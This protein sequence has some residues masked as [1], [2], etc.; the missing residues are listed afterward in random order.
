MDHTPAIAAFV[1][2]LRDSTVFGQVRITRHGNDFELQHRDQSASAD[3][4]SIDQLRS[5]ADTAA[6]G[7]YR[8]LKSSPNLKDGWLCVAATLGELE[9][10]L[11]HLYPGAIADWHAG[12]NGTPA[13]SYR[14]H[15]ERQT[16]MYR[17]ANM[18]DADGVEELAAACCH[19]SFCLKTRRWDVNDVRD[20]SDDG[21]PCLEPC[22]VL[23]EF[24][25]KAVRI[26]QED[27]IEIALSASE[28][29]SLLAGIEQAKPTSEDR[30]ADFGH[31]GNPR[32]LELLKN[33]L[34]KA[35]PAEA[36]E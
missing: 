31:A 36:S 14:E 17:I 4:V 1:S 6:A 21:I 27:R 26:S 23:M 30:E 9:R 15:M 11:N 28:I 35:R 5:I 29:D 22:A 20:V 18:L 8:P 25:R 24:A 34:L 32:R 19:E 10:A 2:E 12:R 13:T 7:A 33:K 16:G 3:P